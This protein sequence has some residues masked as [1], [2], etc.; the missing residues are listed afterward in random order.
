MAVEN[1]TVFVECPVLGIPPPSVL[2]MKD[3]QPLLDF[4]YRNIQVCSRVLL[5]ACVARGD[6]GLSNR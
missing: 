4:P 3:R 1:R 5:T 2:W 6:P